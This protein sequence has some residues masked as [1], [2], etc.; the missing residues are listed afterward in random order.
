MVPVGFAVAAKNALICFFVV[1]DLG[2][3]VIVLKKSEKLMPF[4]KN[5]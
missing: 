2:I 4:G 1:D 3:F 5:F